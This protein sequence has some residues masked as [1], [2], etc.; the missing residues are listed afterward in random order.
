MSRSKSKCPLTSM[1]YES[2][3]PTPVF[4]SSS[5][6]TE[7]PKH[8]VSKDRRIEVSYHADH[9]NSWTEELKHTAQTNADH[10]SHARIDGMKQEDFT[11]RQSL[12]TNI[13]KGDSLANVSCA[14]VSYS[15]DNDLHG[16]DTDRY[17]NTCTDKGEK[18]SIDGDTL[19]G[20]SS[21]LV[22]VADSTV[23]H[24]ATQ[25]DNPASG[26]CIFCL[27]KMQSQE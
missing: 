17:N 11:D 1:C 13:V 22:S 24:E 16:T 26:S 2:T 18:G 8:L 14:N 3:D 12:S 20:D 19:H 27:E 4:V 21:S 15:C 23:R 10:Q 6:C 5:V 7:P 9:Q 25:L